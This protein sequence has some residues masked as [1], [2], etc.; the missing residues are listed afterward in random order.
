MPRL[1]I[2]LLTTGLLM[3]P[4]GT[5]PSPLAQPAPTRAS[6]DAW[7]ACTS[8]EPASRIAGCT[9]VLAATGESAANR[10]VALRNRGNAHRMLASMDAALADLSLAVDIDR[11]SPM[12]LVE[13]G[14]LLLEVG[15]TE[16]A[17]EVLPTVQRTA[18]AIARAPQ[19]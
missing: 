7:Q 5:V 17:R 12:A 16:R 8:T 19:A 15:A 4:W 14:A 6:A 10:A 18:D 11:R 1:L 2:R 3:A 13:R 9:R